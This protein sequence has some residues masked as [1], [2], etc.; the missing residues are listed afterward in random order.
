MIIPLQEC[1]TCIVSIN[2]KGEDDTINLL[3]S[4]SEQENG[5]GVLIV[6]NTATGEK[7][8]LVE[9]NYPNVLVIYN[10]ENIGFGSANNKGAAFLK[11]FENIENIFILNNDAF[12]NRSDSVLKLENILDETDFDVLSP[13]I[14]DYKSRQIWFFRG[15]FS[16]LNAGARS[17]LK[18]QDINS[19]A[20]FERSYSSEFIT[21]CAM[22][23]KISTYFQLGGFDEKYFMYVED[24]DLC[25]RMKKAGLNV[26]ATREVVIQHK[27]H[28]SIVGDSEKIIMPLDEDNANRSFY[29]KNVL[30]NSFL[31]ADSNLSG[32]YLFAFKLVLLLK[33]IR[34]ASRFK[35]NESKKEVF[36]LL[37]RNFCD[38]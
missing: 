10:D 11:Q 12:F 9:R 36:E 3:R 21:G 2:Y 27:S 4:I 34:N 14:Q 8:C 23:M 29:V 30:T 16:L 32:F 26:G 37:K 25:Y 24:V 22:F 6:D 1:K 19:I 15:E 7:L 35:K 5:I 20:N 38:K 31:F 33:W 17:I 13:V 18:G 28:S